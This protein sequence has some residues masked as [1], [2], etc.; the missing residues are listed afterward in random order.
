MFRPT[1]FS[2]HSP[3]NNRDISSDNSSPTSSNLKAHCCSYENLDIHAFCVHFIVHCLRSLTGYSGEKYMFYYTYYVYI[4][5]L[6]TAFCCVLL[7]R[8]CLNLVASFVDSYSST[9]LLVSTGRLSFTYTVQIFVRF[10]RV[11][12]I[13]SA[14]LY[15]TAARN[16]D[17]RVIQEDIAMT[18]KHG[19]GLH[20][21]GKF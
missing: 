13:N 9:S 6:S 16:W 19:D 21:D 7:Y 11:T 14:N 18:A 1:W 2:Q 5:F 20:D 17:R 4:G 3:P 8:N 10:V 15:P 12:W